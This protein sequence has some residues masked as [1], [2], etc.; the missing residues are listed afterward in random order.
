MGVYP[1]DGACGDAQ[2]HFRWHKREVGSQSSTDTWWVGAGEASQHLL[3]LQSIIAFHWC[4]GNTEHIGMKRLS[5]RV[6]EFSDTPMPLF[7]F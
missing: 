4:E 2:R 6:G 3:M 1:G 7:P 5:P